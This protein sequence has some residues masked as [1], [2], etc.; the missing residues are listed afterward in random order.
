MRVIIYTL[1]LPVNSTNLDGGA[2]TDADGTITTYAWTKISGTGTYAAERVETEPVV[3]EVHV[4][5]RTP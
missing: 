1:T 4:E 5:R 2:S 3:P